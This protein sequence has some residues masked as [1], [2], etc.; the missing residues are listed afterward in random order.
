MFFHLLYCPYSKTISKLALPVSYYYL[1]HSLNNLQLTQATQIPEE[2]SDPWEDDKKPNFPKPTKSI[3]R[4]GAQP[5]ASNGTGNAVI[6]TRR[7]WGLSD[8]HHVMAN[9]SRHR[10]VLRTAS[11]AFRLFGAVQIS[12]WWDKLRQH[13]VLEEPA[14]SWQLY[15][16]LC[17]LHGLALIW[18][19]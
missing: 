11:V 19:C 9:L 3:C 5:T 4:K 2:A 1:W 12:W 15:Q 13:I 6:L 18:K 16:S 8:P 14:G 10:S 17:H 7:H